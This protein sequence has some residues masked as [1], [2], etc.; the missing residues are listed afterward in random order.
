MCEYAWYDN[1]CKVWQCVQGM[2]VC[3]GSKSDKLPLGKHRIRNT[4]PYRSTQMCAHCV[5]VAQ[6]TKCL[7]GGSFLAAC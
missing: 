6:V 1:V 5:Y 7:S 2:T 3:V 4:P